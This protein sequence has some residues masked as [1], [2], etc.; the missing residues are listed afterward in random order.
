MWTECLDAWT[1]GKACP[2]E[3]IGVGSLFQPLQL[4]DRPTPER[5]IDLAQIPALPQVIRSIVRY[6]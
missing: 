1:H 2:R 4:I 5:G 6:T 3:A